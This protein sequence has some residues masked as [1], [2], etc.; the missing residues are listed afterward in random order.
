MQTLNSLIIT[1]DM[2][3]SV[4]ECSI[5]KNLNVCITYAPSKPL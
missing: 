3:I 2:W 5:K 4:Y 1:S